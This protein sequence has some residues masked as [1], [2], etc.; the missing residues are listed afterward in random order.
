MQLLSP[1]LKL[2]PGLVIHLSKHFPLTIDRERD[3]EEFL[4]VGLGKLNL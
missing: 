3:L 2:L 1:P 4:S